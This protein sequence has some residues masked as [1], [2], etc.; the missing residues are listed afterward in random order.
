M[1]FLYDITMK[2]ISS[3]LASVILLAACAGGS[4]GSG[5][6]A[7]DL[8]ERD[9]ILLSEGLIYYGQDPEA[10]AFDDMYYAF[11]A[12]DKEMAE[13]SAKAAE[14]FRQKAEGL[15]P[16]K[17]A[18]LK[19]VFSD[20]AD[21][22]V[23]AE[24]AY[25]DSEVQLPEG[26]TDL[27]TGDPDLAKLIDRYS[28]KGLKCSLMAKGDRKVLVF[29]G[30]DFPGSWT[31]MGMVMHFIMDA[32]EDVYGALNADASQV[33]L[34]DRLVGELLSSGY[35]SRGSLEFAG[36][37]L[38]GRLASEMAVRYGCPA[39]IFNAAGVS[40]QVYEAYDAARQA[41]DKDWR[42][43]IVD[44]V[45][46]NDPLTCAQKYMS[47]ASDP[48][49]SAAAEALSVDKKTVEG[50]LSV[51]MGILGA[52]VDNVAGDSKVVKTAKAL[53]ER[54][55]DVVDEYYERDYRAL[56]AV[57]PLREDMGGHG[58]KELAA[59]LRARADLL[60]QKK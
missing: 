35:V 40:P 5:T 33:V 3:I 56:G 21:L 47:G 24:Y 19:D 25:R 51:G 12:S 17:R 54:Y 11:A 18:F 1:N 30:T 13:A 4:G 27:G 16:Q 37:S 55:G 6:S 22:A 2:R 26:W 36:H 41:A 60:S 8:H 43:Y 42:G 20:Y 31:D 53:T 58:I 9:M 38:G 29:A 7:A 44:V 50:V 52:V 14:D 49:V 45:A 10:G 23:M 59:V 34:A 28:V 57:M 32:Y 48:F 46:A 39:V 15:S